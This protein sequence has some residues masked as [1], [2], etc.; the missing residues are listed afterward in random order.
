MTQAIKPIETLYNGF[1][2]RSRLEARWAVFLDGLGVRYEYEPEGFEIPGVGAYLPDFRV[3]C[4]ARR[5]QECEPFPLYIEVKGRMDEKSAEKIKAFSYWD[6]YDA[7]PDKHP[8]LIVGDIPRIEYA[9]DIYDERCTDSYTSLG[10]D[11]YPFNYE[12]IDGDHFAAYP[13]VQDGRFGLLGDDGS[14]ICWGDHLLTTYAYIAARRARFK[15]G[16]KPQLPPRDWRGHLKL[17]KAQ[18]MFGPVC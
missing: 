17:L 14:Y 7:G 1:R 12:T 9:S 2:F 5:G 6:G 16:E 4:H 3:M 8:L 15:H 10:F 18:D 13:C 11:L